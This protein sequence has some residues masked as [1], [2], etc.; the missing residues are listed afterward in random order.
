VTPS[1]DRGTMMPKRRRTQAENLA[2]RIEAERKLNDAY[3]AER[4]KP[5]PF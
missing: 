5:P 1:D 2:K 4:N 3:I